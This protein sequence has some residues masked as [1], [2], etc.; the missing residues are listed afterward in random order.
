MI[1]KPPVEPWTNLIERDI[2]FLKELEIL[3]TEVVEIGECPQPIDLNNI[4]DIAAILDEELHLPTQRVP[5]KDKTFLS[6]GPCIDKS[7]Y[8][9]LDFGREVTGFPTPEPF[10]LLIIYKIKEVLLTFFK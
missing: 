9:V 4:K 1:G 2:P 8:L 7:I 6:I 3:P 5:E 10:Q